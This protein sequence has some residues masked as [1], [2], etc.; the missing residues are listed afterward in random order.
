M[1]FT[2]NTEISQST[3]ML[4][5]FSPFFLFVCNYCNLY[6]TW[7][8]LLQ[9]NQGKLRR[10][11]WMELPVYSNRFSLANAMASIFS[12]TINLWVKIHVVDDNRISSSQVQTLPSSSCGQQAGKYRSVVIECVYNCLS[13]CH[14][15]T[16]IEDI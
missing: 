10:G 3:T 15:C 6:Y 12:L 5:S 16:A 4:L 14:L 1:K 13:V 7:V 8:F 11:I 2:S 9:S